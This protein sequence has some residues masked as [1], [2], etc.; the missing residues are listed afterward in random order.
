MG[1]VL[2][3]VLTLLVAAC[4]SSSGG[5]SGPGGGAAAQCHTLVDKLCNGLAPCQS[6]T[7]AQCVDSANQ[8]FQQQF[9]ATCDGADQV[10][11]TYDACMS[12]L[13]NYQ[14][15]VTPATCQSVILFVQ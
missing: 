10:S 8:Q 9:G 7:H 11:S 3:F 12:D 6:I 13:D 15:G 4:S 1:K 2:G 5:G 14:C